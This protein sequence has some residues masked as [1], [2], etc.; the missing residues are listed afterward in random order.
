[1]LRC[2]GD[3]RLTRV[4]KRRLRVLTGVDAET[5]GTEAALKRLIDFHLWRYSGDSA[6]E[7]LL[8]A[9]FDTFRIPD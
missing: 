3:I 4:E 8:R 1:M 2:Q 5:I 9:F 7:K 6:E